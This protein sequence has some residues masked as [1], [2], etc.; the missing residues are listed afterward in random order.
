LVP[1]PLHTCT[2]TSTSTVQVQPIIPLTDMHESEERSRKFERLHETTY[3][4]SL[5]AGWRATFEQI[6]RDA[7][8][9]TSQHQSST[10]DG[11]PAGRR[12]CRTVS[13]TRAYVDDLIM[14]SRRLQ[15]GPTLPLQVL[16]RCVEDARRTLEGYRQ[17]VSEATCSDFGLSQWED[18]ESEFLGFLQR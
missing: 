5:E 1:R 9:A 11:V 17:R 7:K 6:T 13:E 18:A 12:V 16:I 2:S 8:C 14:R 4:P 15:D 10:D 3:H